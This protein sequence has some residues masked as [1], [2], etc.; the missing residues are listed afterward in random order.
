ML[1]GKIIV[2]DGKL[3]GISSDGEWL[4]RKVLPETLARPVV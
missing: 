1:M 4:P 3:V 2:E